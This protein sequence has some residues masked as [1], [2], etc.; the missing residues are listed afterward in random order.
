MECG[1]VSVI[2]PVYNVERY[3]EYCVETLINQ[4]YRNLE[5]ILIDDG[6][7]DNSGK[8]CDALANKDERIQVIHQQNQGL[9][10]ARNSGLRVVTGEYITCVDSDDF[11]STDFIE[12]LLN[13]LIRENADIAIC[14]TT[15]CDDSGNQLY[16]QMSDKC[17][18]LNG[19]NQLKVLLKDSRIYSTTAWGKIYKKEL[20]VGI[21]YP[22]NKYHEDIYTT[23]R[24]VANSM[25]TVIVPAALYWYRQATISITHSSFNPK[26]MDS[27]Y[28]CMDRA[29]FILQNYPSLYKYASASIAYSAS[30]LFEK[31]I[32]SSVEYEECEER[33]HTAICKNFMNFMIW[34]KSGIMTKLFAF[35]SLINM[36]LAKKLYIILKK[37]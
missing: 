6:S 28:G 14:G 32:L 16:D 1:K 21:E 15:F 3:L 8:I 7:T 11:L 24:L 5:V 19:D 27:L 20:F 12:R 2:V 31:M 22:K 30:I 34:S 23:Y 17:L 9:S 4:S 10:A 35:F 18:I 25:K 36:K 13:A 37:R 29:E 33:I 26:H